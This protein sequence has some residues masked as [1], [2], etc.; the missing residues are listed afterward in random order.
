MNDILLDRTFDL[1]LAGGDWK[2]GE[3]TRQH[4]QLLLLTEKGEWKENPTQGVGSQSWLLD[5]T[6]GEYRAEVKRQFERDGMT[7]L[8]LAGTMKNLKVEAI[9]G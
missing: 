2:I 1:L 5:E 3:S 6:S 8:K 9:Y 4:Q 7:V